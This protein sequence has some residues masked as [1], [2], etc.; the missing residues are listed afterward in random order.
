MR[1][2]Q[3]YVPPLSKINKY[4]IIAH[5]GLFIFNSILKASAGSN[6]VSFLGLSFNGLSQGLVYQ[7]FTFP[8]IE[9][10]FISVLFNSMLVWFIGGD[11]ETR[12]GS[13]FYAKFLA[14]SAF[15]AGIVYLAVTVFAGPSFQFIPLQ[16]LGGV[17]FALLVAYGI[18]FAD[19]YLTF[20]LLFPMKAKYFC[21]ILGGIELYMGLFSPHGKASWAH[22]SAAVAGFIYLKLKSMRARGQNL[23]DFMKKARKNRQKRN[24]KIVRDED[25]QSSDPEDP[26][27]WQ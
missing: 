16:G 17:V 8:F 1:Q 15:S 21:M 6:L 20:M 18:I 14:I 19:R 25:R 11:L 7:L 22:L 27:Y 9:V 4:I 13:Y 26:K 2:A 24:L 3:M 12:W 10:S 23:G 5:V